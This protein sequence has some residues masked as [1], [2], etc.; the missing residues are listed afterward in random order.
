M[1]QLIAIKLFESQNCSKS[2]MQLLRSLHPQVFHAWVLQDSHWCCLCRVR[3]NLL[4]ALKRLNRW[5]LYVF[6]DSLASVC[7]ESS[8]VLLDSKAIWFAVFDLHGVES[9]QFGHAF[10]FPKFDVVA[11]LE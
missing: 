4:E 7:V 10:N 11:V 1:G 9:I 2:Q 5:N 8:R 3:K 6:N